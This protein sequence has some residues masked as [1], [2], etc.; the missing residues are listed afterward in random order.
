M[1]KVFYYPAYF[2]MRRRGEMRAQIIATILVF[3]ATWF[4]HQYQYYWLQGRAHISLN[5]SIFWT[6]LCALMCRE[7]LAGG[8][9][10]KRLPATGWRSGLS[11]AAHVAGTFALISFLWSM[12][13]ANSLTE[14]VHFLRTGNI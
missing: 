6:I 11:R 2:K 12:W 8:S 1:V 4:L 3:A 9:R 14:W 7:I 10:R 5:D 13:S